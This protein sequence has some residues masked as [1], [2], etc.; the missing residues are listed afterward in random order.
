MSRG[1]GTTLYVTVSP[2]SKYTELFTSSP[3]SKET[4]YLDT[5]YISRASAQ[6]LVPV[7]SPTNLSGMST[8][9][10][11]STINLECDDHLI[12]PYPRP[13]SSR[14]RCQPLVPYP[15]SRYNILPFFV[16]SSG[17]DFSDY[18]YI[19]LGEKLKWRRIAFL[20]WSLVLLSF[21]IP[22]CP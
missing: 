9:L 22:S 20:A 17:H 6:E 16:R 14:L 11:I 19:L 4:W 13:S 18:L 8:N 7:T 12:P 10:D 1:G 3:S 21:Q 5:N 15:P 2:P